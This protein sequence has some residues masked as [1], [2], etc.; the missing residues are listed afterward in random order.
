MARTH[1]VGFVS[2]IS[3]ELATEDLALHA[4]AHHGAVLSLPHRYAAD[5]AR[6]LR[7]P[8]A[9]HGAP[10]SLPHRYAA[11]Q[12]RDLRQLTV[13]RRGRDRVRD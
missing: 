2:T 11:D 12:A 9:H 3:T 8:S 4:S 10:P 5:R 13:A 1:L 7:Q 6:D